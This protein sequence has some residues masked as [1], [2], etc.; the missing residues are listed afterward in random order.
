MGD[1]VRS[2]HARVLHSRVQQTC[3]MRATVSACRASFF[4]S[5]SSCTAILRL[6]FSS[7][8]PRE[9]AWE[10][11]ISRRSYP[12]LLPTSPAAAL[13]LDVPAVEPDM[14]ARCSVMFR[15]I[16][17]QRSIFERGPTPVCRTNENVAHSPHLAHSSSHMIPRT[18][19]SSSR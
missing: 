3:C 12:A 7:L 4:I 15:V 14:R 5:C 10:S 17:F 11:S 6:A 16:I 19:N 13:A 1:R 18:V 9:P 8:H 2:V